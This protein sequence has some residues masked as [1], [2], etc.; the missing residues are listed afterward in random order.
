MN[1]KKVAKVFWIII[2]ILL[3]ISLTGSM[4]IGVF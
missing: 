1:N 2:V 3:I 4:F